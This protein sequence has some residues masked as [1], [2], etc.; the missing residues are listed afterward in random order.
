MPRVTPPP[1]SC[2]VHPGWRTTIADHVIALAWS[3][4]G[5]WLAAAAVSGP[6][7]LLDGAT[8]ELQAELPG[9]TVGTTALSWASDSAL[10]ASAGQDGLVRL[11]D[12]PGGHEH[13]ALEAGAAWVERLAWSPDGQYLATAAGRSLRLW[14]RDRAL[15]QT[16]PPH[17]STI[18]DIQWAPR[19]VW[20]EGSVPVL[21]SAAYGGINL[22]TPDTPEPLEQLTWKGSILTLAWSPDGQHLAHGDQDATVHFRIMATGQDAKM[23]G[24]PTKVRELAWDSTGRYLATGGGPVVTVWDF[25]GKGPQG[26]KPLLLEAHQDFLS[27]LAFQHAGPLLVSGAHDGLVAFWQPGPYRKTLAQQCL[28]TGITQTAWAPDDQ[29]LAIGAEDGTVTVSGVVR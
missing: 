13:G 28:M 17:S 18:A 25:A 2:T 22:W 26:S 15:I 14:N 27:T 1:P 6:L 29:S 4:D 20:V 8:G 23:W 7:V 5:R 9:H 21:T 12:V 11:W 24:Y 10:L 19:Q 16:Y 3:P